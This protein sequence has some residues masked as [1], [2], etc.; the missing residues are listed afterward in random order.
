MSPRNVSNLNMAKLNIS[1]DKKIFIP[2]IK[3]KIM[4]SEKKDL[5]NELNKEE[6]ANNV[7][8]L[9]KGKS[10][11]NEKVD[12]FIDYYENSCNYIIFLRNSSTYLNKKDINWYKDISLEDFFKIFQKVSLFGLKI[13]YLS[14]NLTENYNNNSNNSRNIL[15]I[16]YSL[17]LS[18]FEI[19]FNTKEIILSI[20]DHLISINKCT[21]QIK[22]KIEENYGKDQLININ[23]INTVLNLNNNYMEFFPVEK[24]PGLK[25]ILKGYSKITIEFNENKP[26][27]LRNNFYHQMKEIINILSI[28]NISINNIYGKSFFSI[29][30]TPY[31]C[32]SKNN[33]QTSFVNYYQ[34]KINEE[35]KTSNNKY[36]DIPLIG[37]L[38]LKFN[39]KF[40][41]E[42]INKEC[43]N[44][45]NISD[46]MIVNRLIQNVT[47][48][49]IQNNNGNNSIDVE[50][51]LNQQLNIN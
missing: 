26:P 35:R 3:Q 33:I 15:L 41:L 40:F 18:S 45:N 14:N 44:N 1:D 49:F 42:K 12:Y 16:N 51:Y 22:S 25:I 28:S 9:D 19:S 20:I 2:T 36:I 13:D 6:N 46:A 10:S 39:N 34:F 30:F 5:K 11:S 32:R 23:N 38:P 27:H 21:N 7:N 24:N 31:N 29:R 47:S 8:Q 37:I 4:E 17:T 43:Y 50:Y 48:N